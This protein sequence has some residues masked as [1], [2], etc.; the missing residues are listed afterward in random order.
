MPVLLQLSDF[1][2]WLM[3]AAG[4]ELSGQWL[5]ANVA[6]IAAGE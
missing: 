2:G 5:F 6:G 4:A 1:D 3:G